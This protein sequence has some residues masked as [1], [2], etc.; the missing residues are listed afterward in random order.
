MPEPRCYESSHIVLNRN[1][2]AE[3][4][5][6]L[7][8]V[9]VTFSSDVVTLRDQ[10]HEKHQLE[11]L[12]GK[13][14]AAVQLKMGE[15]ISCM[16]KQRLIII[17]NCMASP[18]SLTADQLNDGFISF[19]KNAIKEMKEQSARVSAMLQ[20]YVS[21]IFT[22]ILF[23][24]NLSKLWLFLQAAAAAENVHDADY[25]DLSPTLFEGEKPIEA[26]AEDPNG[27]DVLN[28]YF[29]RM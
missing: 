7:L 21:I 8:I 1:K 28:F 2:D 4:V 17:V 16:E 9:A 15:N 24:L 19:K 6:A 13:D 23:L 18:S 5:G 14:E 26:E 29:N 12:L 11:A 25:R 10:L 27:D 22:P 3:E 20:Q